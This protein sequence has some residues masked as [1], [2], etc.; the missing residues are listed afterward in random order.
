MRFGTL[1]EWALGA[2]FTRRISV[3]KLLLLS[4]LLDKKMVDPS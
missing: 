4:M 3:V 2:D 1:F